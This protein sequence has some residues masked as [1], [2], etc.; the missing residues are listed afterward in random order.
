MSSFS[1]GPGP[2]N[3]SEPEAH[4]DQADNNSDNSEVIDSV[5]SFKDPSPSGMRLQSS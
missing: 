3:V 4:S 1:P 2:V 5:R